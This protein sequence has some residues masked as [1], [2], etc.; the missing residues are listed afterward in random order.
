MPVITF[1]QG[2][3]PVPVAPLK[4]T[5][6]QAEVALDEA[7]LYELVVELINHPDTPPRIK[8]AWKR[9]LDIERDN[10]M[11]LLIT[12]KLELTETEVDALFEVAKNITPGAL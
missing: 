4:I 11:V 3:T 1:A 8:F 7:G 5:A 9:G 12:E 10:P 6:Y 2:D